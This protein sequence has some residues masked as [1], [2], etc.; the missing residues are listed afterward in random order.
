M[1]IEHR[2]EQQ[3]HTF[4]TGASGYLGGVVAEHLIKAG[5]EVSALVRSDGSEARVIT[6]GAKPVRGDLTSTDTLRKAAAAS[7]TVVHTAVDYMT[8]RIGHRGR[9]DRPEHIPATLEGAGRTPSTPGRERHRH[10]RRADLRP[11]R[12]RPPGRHVRLRPAERP[13]RLH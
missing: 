10:P 3:M 7:D 8:P 2:R 5:H 13:D 1:D 12:L 6:L 9:P 4:M 11:R